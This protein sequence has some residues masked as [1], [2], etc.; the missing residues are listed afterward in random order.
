MTLDGYGAHTTSKRLNF[1]RQNND[2]VIALPAHWSHRTQALA[3]YIFYPFKTYIFYPFNTKMRNAL[4]ER[5]LAAEGSVRNDIYI[6]GGLI[7]N[8]YKEQVTYSN[9]VNGF[10][11]CGEFCALRRRALP[12]VIEITDISKTE[13][14]GSRKDAFDS[15]E[16]LCD[17]YI[18]TRNLLRSD[19]PVLQNG[20]LNTRGGL[21]LTS[22]EVF[23][24]LAEREA[25]RAAASQVH[26]E[27]EVAAEELRSQ[28]ERA[29]AAY[30]CK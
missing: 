15:F 12:E 28:S 18:N 5:I 11:A 13:S 1:L 3:F 25:A 8:A 21:L 7:D 29:K 17:S 16:S 14:H 24:Q 6:P 26:K 4:N 2:V 30:I 10:K 23:K 9:I 22:N 20:T 19:G 27:R